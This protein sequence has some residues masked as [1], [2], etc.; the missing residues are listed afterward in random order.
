MSVNAPIESGHAFSTTD[1]LT[2]SLLNKAFEL[3]RAVIPT[4]FGTA[5]GGTGATS[6]VDAQKNLQAM[7]RLEAWVEFGD[8]GNA[9]LL[10]TLPA[11]SFV[12]DINIHCTTAFNGTGTDLISV[13]WTADPDALAV[14][15]DVASTGVLEPIHGANDGY[16]GSQQTV[17]AY[18]VDALGTASAGK[19]LVVVLFAQV[20]AQP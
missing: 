2:A 15:Q 6:V 5:N 12:Y 8:D 4:P 13:G 3:A 16:N 1:T 11:D 9:V 14:A 10:G 7:G 18:Y 17:N 19:A 20:T